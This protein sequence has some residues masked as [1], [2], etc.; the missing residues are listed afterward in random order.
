MNHSLQVF[1]SFF[2]PPFNSLMNNDIM[3]RHVEYSIAKYAKPNCKPVWVVAHQTKIIEQRN[4]WETEYNRKPIVL[5]K[6]V[7]MYSMM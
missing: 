6:C 2:G 4:G 7:I 1:A 3:K 5:L